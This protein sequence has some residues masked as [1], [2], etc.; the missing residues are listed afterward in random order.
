[1]LLVD[2]L[3]TTGA[4]MAEGAKLLISGGAAAVLAVSVAQT[5]RKTANRTN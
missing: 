2:D 4:G 1:V 5:E 3:I